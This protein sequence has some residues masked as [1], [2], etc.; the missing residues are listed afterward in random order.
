M[1]KSLNERRVGML[2]AAILVTSVEQD[3]ETGRLWPALRDLRKG[4]ARTLGLAG[5]I[6]CDANRVMYGLEGS[7]QYLD[8]FT[9][10]LEDSPCES[11]ARLLL[12]RPIVQRTY[13]AHALLAPTLAKE[14]RTWLRDELDD[15]G[16]DLTT[17]P[18]F[19]TW[20]ALRQAET[21]V[22]G[23][24]DGVMAPS[25]A[26]PLSRANTTHH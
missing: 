20:L 5:V 26:F 17:L 13:R 24:G 3:F 2:E 10:M 6:L 25:D 18:T 11:G 1:I 23:Y 7:S 4:H 8:R 9:Q 19:L 14:E 15:S 21:I 16:S 22:G 12:R